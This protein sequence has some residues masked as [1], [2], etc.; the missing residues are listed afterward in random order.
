MNTVML[1]KEVPEKVRTA[2]DVVMHKKL[3]RLF[4][5]K[6][7]QGISPQ[8][9]AHQA[10]CWWLSEAVDLAQVIKGVELGGKTSVNAQ[11]L[12]V[13]DRSQGQSAE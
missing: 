2:A 5:S 6:L 12:L 10:V 11:E 7:L 8:K 9:V 13:H 4:L 3:G 1:E